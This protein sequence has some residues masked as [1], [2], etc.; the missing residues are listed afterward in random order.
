M[1]CLCGRVPT[2]IMKGPLDYSGFRV[3]CCLLVGLPREFHDE[4]R[5]RDL[6]AKT[7]KLI[8]YLLLDDYISTLDISQLLKI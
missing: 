3:G 2:L 8:W 4:G 7:L 5:S 1:G 6:R